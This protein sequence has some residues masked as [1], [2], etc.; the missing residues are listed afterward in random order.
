MKQVKIKILEME[1]GE[2]DVYNVTHEEPKFMIS[3]LPEEVY[4]FISGLRIM[5]SIPGNSFHI[6]LVSYTSYDLMFDAHSAWDLEEC[7]SIYGGV[8]EDH[9]TD[10]FVCNLIDDTVSN[11]YESV[12]VKQYV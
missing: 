5:D 1:Q 6:T 2:F 3:V 12:G 10:C 4:S 9:P 11:Y 7:D 8:F